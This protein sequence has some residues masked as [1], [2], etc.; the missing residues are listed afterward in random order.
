MKAIAQTCIPNFPESNLPSMFIYYEGDLRKQ[1]V[2]PLEF[3]GPNVTIEGITRGQYAYIS[4]IFIVT[5]IFLQISN[6]YWDKLV[7]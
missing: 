2:G 6:I 1:I 4:Y 3:R 7:L 5:L